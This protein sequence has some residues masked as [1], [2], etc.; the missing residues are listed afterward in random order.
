MSSSQPTVRDRAQ[1]LANTSG[2]TVW[3]EGRE[4]D[5]ALVELCALNPTAAEVAAAR[6]VIEGQHQATLAHHQHCPKGVQ[7]D[8]DS[9]KYGIRQARKSAIRRDRMLEVLARYEAV[10]HHWEQYGHL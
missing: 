7:V 2:L 5:V 6:G 1:L 9:F 10:A 8:S 4:G 3:A